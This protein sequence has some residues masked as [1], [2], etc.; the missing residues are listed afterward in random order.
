[1]Q[2]TEEQLLAL[3]GVGDITGAQEDQMN[4][5]K[6]A[7][8]LRDSA[9][10]QRYDVGSNIGRAA[11][12]VAG[13]LSDYRGMGASKDISGMKKNLL[14]ILLRKFGGGAGGDQFSSDASR[15]WDVEGGV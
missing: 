12:G 10:K 14:S 15:M 1:M 3:L 11:Y 13:A 5:L 7:Q 9:P 6:L 4:Q 8:Q 2:L